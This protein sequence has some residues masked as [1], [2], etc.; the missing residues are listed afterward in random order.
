MLSIQ[1]RRSYPR[2]V[3]TGVGPAILLISVLA[4]GCASVHVEPFQQFAQAA[5]ELQDNVNTA[6][7]S[8]P[9]ASEARFVRQ[10][11][12]DRGLADQLLLR[13]DDVDPILWNPESAPLFLTAER[14][15]TGV[16]R[17]A[18]VFVDYSNVL[19]ELASP[20]LL[21]TGQFDQ[22]ATDLTANATS[23]LGALL[24][25]P[26]D[27]EPFAMFSTVASE[28]FRNYLESRRRSVMLE[29]LRANQETIRRFSD[30][31]V[32]AT[33]IAAELSWQ[34]YSELAG[35]ELLAIPGLASRRRG[36]R[37]RR[38]AHDRTGARAYRTSRS[39]GNPQGRVRRAAVV[40]C[41][42]DQCRGEPG[43][44]TRRDQRGARAEPYLGVPV[45]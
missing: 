5:V 32:E 3:V 26:V 36:R 21:E 23:G 19:V 12:Q 24:G 4:S 40:S 42:T 8:G 7:A 14:F 28:L 34:E 11:V 38:G 31:L 30:L 41:R 1:E 17:V 27:A 2:A 6:L 25:R 15:R 39:I 9:E 43:R 44:R 29:A 18:G 16:R 33:E 35:D 13:S 37:G 45:R 22:L 10:L 20:E